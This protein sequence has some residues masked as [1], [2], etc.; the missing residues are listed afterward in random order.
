[1]CQPAMRPP[2]GGAGG[3]RVVGAGG[4]GPLH[5]RPQEA[6][7]GMPATSLRRLASIA[8]YRTVAQL[9]CHQFST[10]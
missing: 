1:M 3:V 4:P 5:R 9:A 6:G 7:P 8:V 10:F 2:A